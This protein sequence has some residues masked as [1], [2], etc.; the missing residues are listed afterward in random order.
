M[1]QVKMTLEYVRGEEMGVLK[2]AIALYEQW[3]KKHSPTRED[4]L[5]IA[6]Y[7]VTEVE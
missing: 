2:K 4:K 1:R 7:P 5:E 3:E 6:I